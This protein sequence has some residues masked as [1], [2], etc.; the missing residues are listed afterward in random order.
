MVVIYIYRV[1]IC[2]DELLFSREEQKLCRDILER[3]N[4]KYSISV[5]SSGEKLLNAV[6]E[7]HEKYDLILM[8]I[9][10]DGIDGMT[11]AK[12]IRRDD[13]EV[14]IIFI[15]SSRDYA[16]EGYDVNAL[17]YLIKPVDS[18]VLERLIRSDYNKRFCKE[19]ILLDLF[20][21]KGK[22]LVG[23]DE[24]VYLENSNRRVFV[25]LT[26]GMAYYNG[27]LSD[28][29]EI[30]PKDRFVRC[31]QAFAV[32]VQK[33]RELKKREIVAVGKI[34][35]P[36]SRTFAKEVWWAFIRQNTIQ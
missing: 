34:I 23:V 20:Q 21:T 1:A 8:D 16:L 36:V 5:F 12:R 35:I 6:S 19:A 33:I 3:L 14:T 29:L 11:V 18:V 7:G 28:L 24:I 13:S 32:N 9:L 2:E 15:T 25:T 26:T 22:V 30:L 10:M 17:N 27:K 31:H 4:V